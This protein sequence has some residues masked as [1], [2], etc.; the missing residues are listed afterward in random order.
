MEC[1]KTYDD[2]NLVK[3]GDIGQVHHQNSTFKRSCVSL[4]GDVGSQ[5]VDCIDVTRL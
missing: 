3:T 1:Y 5:A 4:Y 2:V